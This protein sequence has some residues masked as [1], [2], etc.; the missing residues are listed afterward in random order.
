MINFVIFVFCLDFDL[1]KFNYKS[2]NQREKLTLL[3]D[4]FFC[5]K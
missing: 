4:I 2:N 5:S 3:N 1:Y